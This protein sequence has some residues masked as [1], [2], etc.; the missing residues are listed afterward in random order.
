MNQIQALPA[1]WTPVAVAERNGCCD[2]A[3]WGRDYTMDRSVLFS[4]IRTQGQELLSAPMRI[5]GREN[6]HDIWWDRQE[7]FVLDAGA[8]QAVICATQESEAVG[9]GWYL[10]LTSAPPKRK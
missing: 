7:T 9:I 5:V 3:L 8:E 4:S 6:G 10:C 1:P 2:I